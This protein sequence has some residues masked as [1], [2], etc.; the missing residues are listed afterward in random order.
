MS[1][2]RFGP[3]SDVYV[4]PIKTGEYE[5]CVCALADGENVTLHNIT[6]MLTH[7][8]GHRDA[9]HMVPEYAF[10]RLREELE[11]RQ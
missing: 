9:G 3:K 4:F 2:C 11:A 6:S 8:Q 7:L 5:C 1:Y 10:K